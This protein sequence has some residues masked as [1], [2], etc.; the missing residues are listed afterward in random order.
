MEKIIFTIVRAAVRAA[1]PELRK[2]I[3]NVFVSLRQAAAATDNQWDD[4]LVE[5]LG[6]VLAFDE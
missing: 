3:K 1:S 4:M 5:I 2:V 6:A